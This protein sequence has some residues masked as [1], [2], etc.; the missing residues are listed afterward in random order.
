MDQHLKKDSLEL[1]TKECE[2][3]RLKRLGF[4][5]DI[6]KEAELLASR[7]P[8]K[9]DETFAQWKSRCLREYYRYKG[10]SAFCRDNIDNP[11]FETLVRTLINTY[12]QKA[13]ESSP[14]TET[15]R[16]LAPDL[17]TVS[18]AMPQSLFQELYTIY[19]SAMPSFGNTSELDRFCGSIAGERF[20][21]DEARI[22]GSLQENDNFYWEKFYTKLRPIT[23]AFCYQMSGITGANNTHDIW[24]DTC[25][26]V[27]RAVVEHR[28]KEPV[29]SKA[30]ISYSVGI[31]KNKN[32]EL[33]RS[34][35][36]TPVDV[37]TL[38]YRLTAEDDEKYFN[39]PITKP[40]NFPSQ[41]PSL[42]T[43]IDYSDKESVQGYFVVI[44][45]NKEHPLH[46]T[47]VKGY[48]DKIG[49]MF[50][51]YIDGM[52]YEE[53]VAR[54]YG[55]TDGKKLTKEC[56]RLRQETKRLK[57]NLLERFYK[58]LEQYR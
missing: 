58:M 56:A 34:K 37:D 13:F 31:L 45:Y 54:H 43:Y 9:E 2:H 6:R 4:L 29:D 14:R 27:N 12:I 35:A 46:D 5:R 1:L 28:L 44:L 36:R 41:I 55:I 20:P 51:H 15:D 23:D 25:I 53:I 42:S 38:Q 30:I 47:L 33:A 16:F 39:N 26:S 57:N 10:F 32:K 19:F 21:V 50:E 24:S 11:D 49:R 48:E 8:P 17:D 22:I 18:Y 40:E 52:S 7:F 3:Y